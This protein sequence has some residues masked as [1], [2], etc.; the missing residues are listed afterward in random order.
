MPIRKQL[1]ISSGSHKILLRTSDARL[2][3]FLLNSR[4]PRAHIPDYSAQEVP[5][6]TT[7]WHQ[8]VDHFAKGRRF[9]VGEREHQVFF[10]QPNP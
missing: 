4:F 6:D 9:V 1:L 8:S 7:D 5:K 2:A 3:D 10:K